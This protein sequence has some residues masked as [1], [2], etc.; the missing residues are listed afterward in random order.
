VAQQATA[1]VIDQALPGGSAVADDGAALVKAIVEVANMSTHP[2]RAHLVWILVL[3]RRWVGVWEL[4]AA[5]SN[6]GPRSREAATRER[7]TAHELEVAARMLAGMALDPDPEARSM[8]YRLVGS[9]LPTNEAIAILGESLLR[10]TD[11]LARACGIEAQALA[12]ARSWP[13]VTNASL[14]LLRNMITVGGEEARGR[15][16]HLRA[17]RAIVGLGESIAAVLADVVD[18]P[19]HLPSEGPFWPVESI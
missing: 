3:M 15:L 6:A 14:N 7:A 2:F 5:S 18:D 17:G 11:N 10:E 1:D 4:A 19:E 9:A 13:H 8:A 16:S 12:L